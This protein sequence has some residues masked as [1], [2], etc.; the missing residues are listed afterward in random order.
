MVV[1]KTRLFDAVLQDRANLF[2][3]L[4]HPVRLQ[5][6][7]F[8]IQSKTCLTGDISGKFPL[9]RT[10]LNQHVKELKNAGLICGHKEGAKIVYCLNYEK[11]KKMEEILTGLLTEIHLPKDFFC[12]Q[13][14]F[15]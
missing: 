2:K 6:L 11:V 8:L 15:K 12:V 10:T 1:S 7:Q 9:T 13:K 4:A 3:A 14:A 5:I